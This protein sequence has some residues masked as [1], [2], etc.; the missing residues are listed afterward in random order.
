MKKIQKI[1]AVS[2]LFLF[3]L[4]LVSCGTEEQDT[5]IDES[6]IPRYSLPPGVSFE[7]SEMIASLQAYEAAVNESL[8]EDGYRIFFWNDEKE[9]VHLT[10]YY[11]DWKGEEAMVPDVKLFWNIEEAFASLY[12]LGQIDE[13]GNVTMTKEEIDGILQLTK[14]SNEVE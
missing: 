6:T 13:N 2:L 14:E 9:F 8:A 5:A 7:R 3:L 11:A 4:S 10:L 1:T 12:N